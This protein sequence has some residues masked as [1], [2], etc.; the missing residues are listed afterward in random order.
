MLRALALLASLFVWATP[1]QA[2]FVA[3]GFTAETFPR[4]TVA[5]N[6]TT[7]GQCWTN[8]ADLQKFAQDRLKVKGYNIVTNPDPAE[9][10]IRFEINVKAF[11]DDAQV[12]IGAIHLRIIDSD[13]LDGIYAD[14][15]YGFHASV[16]KREGNLNRVLFDYVRRMIGQM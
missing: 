9:K 4:L 15:V 13:V 8:H 10:L 14:I 11:R 3:E 12:C 2:Q 16:F 1:A 5:L 7:S 6:D